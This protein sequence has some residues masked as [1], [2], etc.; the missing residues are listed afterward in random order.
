MEIIFTIAVPVIV[1]FV[2]VMWGTIKKQGLLKQRS[3]ELSPLAARQM[4]AFNHA[5]NKAY[6]LGQKREAKV[7]KALESVVYATGSPILTMTDASYPLLNQP[8]VVENKP[9]EELDELIAELEAMPEVQRKQMHQQAKN[10]RPPFDPFEDLF[11]S[12]AS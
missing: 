9:D 4:N 7:Y 12:S 10:R 11:G 3:A 2:W 1:F 8:G 6:A 5:H